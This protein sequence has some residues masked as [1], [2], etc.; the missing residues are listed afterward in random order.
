MSRNTLLKYAAITN[1]CSG[2][3]YI[4]IRGI[5]YLRAWKAR[6]FKQL[7]ACY[8]KARSGYV[9]KCYTY[10]L[11]PYI[12]AQ[13]Q[14][15]SCHWIIWFLFLRRQAYA[16]HTTR[17]FQYSMGGG[18]KSHICTAVDI[19]QQ[20]TSVDHPGGSNKGLLGRGN[21]RQK[22]LFKKQGKTQNDKGMLARREEVLHFCFKFRFPFPH[23]C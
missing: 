7:V 23:T 8:F 14:I 21:M 19:G 2:R 5:S 15:G 13:K 17:C 4:Y 16:Q 20:G 1:N 9:Q 3:R 22:L 10:I 18:T 12:R 11:L 6:G